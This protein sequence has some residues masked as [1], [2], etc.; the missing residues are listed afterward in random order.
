MCGLGIGTWN[1]RTGLGVMVQS[2]LSD[3]SVMLD[4]HKGYSPN[5]YM[6]TATVI[7]NRRLKKSK[8][9]HCNLLRH[10]FEPQCAVSMKQ[11]TA[12]NERFISKKKN[13]LLEK[14][15]FH[16]L[17]VREST[18]SLC[19]H[20]KLKFKNHWSVQSTGKLIE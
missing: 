3:F 20:R 12:E 1:S 7:W 6:F 9:L 17:V 2:N 14:S 16:L 10:R 4:D 15:I 18:C 13:S 19:Q 11:K 5:T 8:V